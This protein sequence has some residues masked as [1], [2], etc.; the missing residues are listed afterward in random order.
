[1]T[2][3]LDAWPSSPANADSSRE[4]MTHFV[5]RGPMTA[6]QDPYSLD[7]PPWSSELRRRRHSRWMGVTERTG[8]EATRNEGQ[9]WWW[10]A[11]AMTTA[12]GFGIHQPGSACRPYPIRAPFGLLP[13]SL[14]VP[15]TPQSLRRRISSPPAPT[16]SYESGR[17]T[18][19][20][21]PV[22]RRWRRTT[23][24][25]PSGNPLVHIQIHNSRVVLLVLLLMWRED[26]D[27]GPK[28]WNH[29]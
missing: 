8:M 7:T 22:R 10:R 9:W 11:A 26:V 14:P 24:S 5:V 28:P 27:P 13:S 3:A 16:A 23:L 25:S 18:P 15:P 21:R 19:R 1:M 6:S 2:T 4:V 12:A 17:T 29:P 20:D